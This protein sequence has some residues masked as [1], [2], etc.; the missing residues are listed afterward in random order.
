[1]KESELFL[2]YTFRLLAVNEMKRYGETINDKQ[3]VEKIPRS[4][5]EKFNFLVVANE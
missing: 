5:D 3:V 4:L 2:D 1:M